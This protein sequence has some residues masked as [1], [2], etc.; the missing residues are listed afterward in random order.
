M[1]PIIFFFLIISPIESMA[2]DAIIGYYPYWM[3]T[4]LPAS[5]VDLD[6][7]THVM[8]AF[9]YP[10]SNGQIVHSSTLLDPELNERVH[11]QG[12]LILLSLGGWGNS[13]GFAPMAADSNSRKEFAANALQ[14]CLQHHYDGIDLDWEH[15]STAS[16]RHNLTLLVKAIRQEFAKLMRPQP[17]LITMAV[18]AGNWAGQWLDYDELIPSIDWFGCMTYDFHGDWTNHAGHN[19]PLYASGGDVDG[20]VDQGFRYLATRHVPLDKIVIGVPFYG[21][22]FNASE[23]YGPTT[24]S[25][26]EHHYNEI[27][28]FIHA[29]WTRHLDDVAKV[30]YLLNPEKSKLISYD[31]TMSVRLKSEYAVEKKLKGVMIWALGQDQLDGRQPLLE[32]VAEPILHQTDV[33]CRDDGA[34]VLLV[35][36][37]PNPFNAT[38]IISFHLPQREQVSLQVYDIHGRLMASLTK[39][40]VPDGAFDIPFKPYNLPSG[41]YIC[42]LS[43]PTFSKIVKMTYCK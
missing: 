38:T 17:M 26:S 19:S 6:R 1:K 4:D 22:G 30:P 28:T 5:A 36:N 24:G 18:T 2:T 13:D 3:K 10:T 34:A 16:D 15:P 8:H 20:S 29:G 11:A 33:G 31:D 32:S 12:R 41:I 27:I 40:F 21:R 43:S 14:F 37:H 23:L 35:S 39:G 9:A 42:R 25:G 7:L